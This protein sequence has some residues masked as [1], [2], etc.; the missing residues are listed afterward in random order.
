MATN[1]KGNLVNSVRLKSIKV[2]TAEII[3]AVLSLFISV[4]LLY[5]KE[6]LILA[7]VLVAAFFL[8]KYF[9]KKY[10]ILRAGSH[11]EIMTEK[12]LKKLPGKYTILSDLEI[13]HKG[14]HAQIDNIILAPNVIFV[15]EVKNYSGNL[16]GAENMRELT[17]ISYYG[18]EKVKKTVYNPFFQVRTHADVVRQLLRDNGIYAIVD[19]G[20]LFTGNNFDIKF[21]LENENAFFYGENTKNQIIKKI[22][23]YG[24]NYK[25][26]KKKAI[27]IIEKN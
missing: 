10:K 3:T 8:N 9:I 19:S 12:L 22:K 23:S 4:F 2:M 11:G 17:K 13:E 16:Y 7:L 20:V 27:K 15:L 25:Y 6:Y 24:G 1:F 14:R 21:D 5:K 18:G 26:D